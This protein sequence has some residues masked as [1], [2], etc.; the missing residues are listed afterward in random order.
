MAKTNILYYIRKGFYEKLIPAGSNTF[1]T[2]VLQAVSGTS[3]YKLYSD[4]APQTIPGTK[5]DV[6]LPYVVMTTLPVGQE[7]DSGT[8]WYMCTVQFL[9]AG[10][11]QSEAEDVAGYLTD[12]LEDSESTLAFTGYYTLS[13]N[14]EPLISQGFTEGVWNIV[15]QYRIIIQP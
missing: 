13:I 2:S 11:T 7:R 8:K 14:R 1:K 9:V 10:S 5:T 15:V 4:L 3:Y 12:L 6:T